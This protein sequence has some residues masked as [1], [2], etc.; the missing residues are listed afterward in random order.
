MQ[1]INS[2]VLVVVAIIFYVISMYCFMWAMSSVS[3]SFTTC[4]GEH[5]VF[6]EVPRCRWA[7]IAGYGFW[8]FGIAGFTLLAIVV[9]RR[10]KNN[11]KST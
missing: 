3:L 7:S 8:G 11:E 2:T 4:S 10:V 9:Y 1:K 5:S 6:H